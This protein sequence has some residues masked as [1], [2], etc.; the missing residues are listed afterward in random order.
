MIPGQDNPMDF[1]WPKIDEYF[2]YNPKLQYPTGNINAT[3]VSVAS[4][5]SFPDAKFIYM[6]DGAPL[7]IG[8]VSNSLQR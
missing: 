5:M 1:E 7:E 2:I 3:N 6:G 4:S 8:G